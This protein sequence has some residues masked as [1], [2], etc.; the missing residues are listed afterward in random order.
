MTPEEIRASILSY[1][2]DNQEN[3]SDLLDNFAHALA[4]RQREAI[5]G[6][7]RDD[8]WGTLFLPNDVEGL[9][10]LIDPHVQRDTSKETQS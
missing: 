7:D 5:E 1:D 9:P 10:D 2:E 8:H 3:L 4:E 6:F